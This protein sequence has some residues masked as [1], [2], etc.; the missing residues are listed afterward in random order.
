MRLIKKIKTTIT[1][2]IHT[3]KRKNYLHKN[4]NYDGEN[5]TIL[6]NNCIGG[7]IYENLNVPYQS[8]TMFINI[9]PLDF[10]KLALNPKHY[11]SMDLVQAEPFQEEF[12]LLNGWKVNFPC[13]YL[14]ELRLMMQHERSFEEAKNKWNRR[15][16]RINYSKILVVMFVE[17]QLMSDEVLN[18]FKQIKFSK[19]LL[20]NNPIVK[21]ERDCFYIDVP[22]GKDW[23]ETKDGVIRYFEIF[24]F[25]SFFDS[26]GIPKKTR[27]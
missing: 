21:N 25:K 14:G 8:P 10:I 16:L 5:L 19:I 17:K 26:C 18:I 23:W 13:A 4:W 22:D 2:K 11:F 27:K 3:R 9:L 7:F 20:S 1:H 24:D 6:S 12:N 15:L